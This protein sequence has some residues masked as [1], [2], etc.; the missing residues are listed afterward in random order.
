MQTAFKLDSIRSSHPIEVPV[1]DALEVDQIF[2]HISYLKGSSCIRMLAAYLGDDVFL[3]GV[4]NYLK[5][6]AYGNAT[7]TDLWKA[8]TEASGKDVTSFMDNW[9]R[10][11]GFPV[12]TVAEEP[13]QIAVRQE[14]FLSTGDVKPDEDKTTWWLP[15]GLRTSPQASEPDKQMALTSKEETIRSID[16]TFYKLNT[17]S[18]AFYRTNYPPARIEKLGTQKDHLSDQD[19]IGIIGDATALALSG[20]GKT[21][22]LL[23]FVESFQSGSNKLI[24][25]QILSSLGDVRSVFAANTELSSALKSFVLKLVTPAAEKI[26]WDFPEGE[27][28]LTAQKRSLLLGAAG[29]AGHKGIIEEAKRRFDLYI[30]G[31]DKKAIHPNLRSVVFR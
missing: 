29:L 10:T 9:I 16:E 23:S 5:A 25:S 6:H 14:R 21:A 13:G 8:L 18:A 3:L 26:G 22:S 30:S 19:K 17:D 7:T 31:K 24:W 28:Y 27:D 12:L 4:S 15:L 1:R 11:I 20:H 2:D